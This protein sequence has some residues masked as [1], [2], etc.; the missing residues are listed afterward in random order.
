[1]L[2]G[3]KRARTRIGSNDGSCSKASWDYFS[4]NFRH[5]VARQHRPLPLR[6]LLS[7]EACSTHSGLAVTPEGVSTFLCAPRCSRTS[8]AEL[9]LGPWLHTT[10]L[11]QTAVCGNSHG[12]RLP[13]GLRRRCWVLDSLS[14]AW[15]QPS[16]GR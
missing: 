4:P 5:H 14:C 6:L 9:I 15:R 13:V 3:T 2:A 8:S 7:L 12:R 11:K 1:M 16:R 10:G